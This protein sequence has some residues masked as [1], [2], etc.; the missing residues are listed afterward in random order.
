MNPSIIISIIALL[1]SAFALGHSIRESRIKRKMSISMKRLSIRD[2]LHQLSFRLVHFIDSIKK[3]DSFEQ[4][5]EILKI[6]VKTAEELTE[7][8]KTLNSKVS[9][10]KTASSDIEIEYEDIHS[11][12]K[13]FERVLENAEN[14]LRNDKYIALLNSVK[15]LQN[16]L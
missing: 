12:M 13:E 1:I 2:Y 5:I 6:L 14:N 15:G 11:K 4:Q 16:R 8:H 9:L 3:H 7:L 10:A